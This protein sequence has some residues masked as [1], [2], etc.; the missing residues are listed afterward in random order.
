[1]Y[2]SR[3][4][5]KA[6]LIWYI[7]IFPDISIPTHD[8]YFDLDEERRKASAATIIEFTKKI[9][10]GPTTPMVLVLDD[11]VCKKYGGTILFLGKLGNPI[12]PQ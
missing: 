12:D 11:F 1:M 8:A 3:G 2:L 9:F 4:G 10:A 7:S 6:Y 5:T